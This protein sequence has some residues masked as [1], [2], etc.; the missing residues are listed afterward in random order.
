MKILIVDDEPRLV[1]VLTVSFQ[2]QWQDAT[3][4][5]ASD[6]EEG[7]ELLYEHD[8][9]VVVLDV[10]LPGMSGLD[11]LRELRRT[12]DVPVIIL[13]AAGDETDQV[14]GLEL[15][16]DGYLVKPF[17]SLALMAHIK[18]VLRRAE[19]AP[20]TDA[21]PDFVAGDLAVHFQ[22]HQVTLRGQDVKLTAVEYKLLYHLVRNAGRLMPRKALLDRVWGKE[23]DATEHYLRVFIS[24]L[25]SKLETTGRAPLITTER[26][27]GYRFVRPMSDSTAQV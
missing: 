2:F 24:R 11:V 6:G 13:S 22:T 5:A 8:P 1:E 18:A 7:L 27:V 10:G 3:V 4:L 14:R 26:G 9:D 20:P 16:A 15:G 12:S 19:L 21:L 17:S 23:Y 25:R